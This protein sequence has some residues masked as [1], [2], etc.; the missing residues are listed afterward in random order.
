MAG[1]KSGMALVLTLWILAILIVLSTGLAIMARNESQISRN[2]SD[3]IRAKWCARAGINSAIVKLSKLDFQQPTYLGEGGLGFTSK[4]DELDLGYGSFEVT[5]QDELGKLNIN[6]ASP[7]ALLELFQ[8]QSIV[9]SIIDWR[10]ED[11]KPLPLGA[12]SDYYLSLPNPYQSKNAP[13][14][15]VRELLLVKGINERVLNARY[16]EDGTKII[17]MITVY[18]SISSS[19]VLNFNSASADV[20]A[21]SLGMDLPSAQKIVNYRAKNGPF[22]DLSQ[23]TDAV[24]VSVPT[25]MM[26]SASSNVFKITSTGRLTPGG[27]SATI[28]CI[29]QFPENSGPQIKY[30]QE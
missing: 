28:S 3:Q 19:P 20:L 30:C 15:T 11:D 12:E 21:L 9:D 25:P 4:N 23:V 26:V 10:D 1:N 16:G 14:D 2:Y 22:V 7:K 29:V 8:D 5:V 24:G 27:A 6:A 13:F 18:S 17:D